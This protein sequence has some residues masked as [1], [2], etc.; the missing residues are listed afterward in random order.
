MVNNTKL[1]ILS[2]ILYSTAVFTAADTFQIPQKSTDPGALRIMTYNVRREG[3]EKK[4]TA[5]EWPNRL[6]LVCALI[7]KINPDI[8]ALQEPV[9][10]QM[11][12]IKDTLI[13]KGMNI[14]SFGESRGPSWQIF[15]TTY[16]PDEYNPIFYNT[17]KYTLSEAE[18]GTFQ[19]NTV[20]N[21][22]LGIWTPWEREQTGMVPR[23]CTWGKFKINATGQE[24]YFY[25]T[26]FDHWYDKARKLCAQNVAKHIAEQNKENLPVIL[27]GDFNTEFKDA[28]KEALAGFEN[29]KDLA[30]NVMGPNETSTGWGDE[31]LKLIDHIV[32]K[33]NVSVTNHAVVPHEGDVYPSDHR[34][35]F[36]DVVIN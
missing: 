5:R 19:I 16:G 3:D 29:T 8:F 1:S 23:I 24:F 14:E 21:S 31:K 35:V 33:G 6:P 36:A 30:A 7:K 15:G 18:S 2:M 4:V 26:H 10:S 20:V 28:V 22:L 34:P 11:Q 17:D 32:S 25:N 9:S 13:A 27:V 12:Q